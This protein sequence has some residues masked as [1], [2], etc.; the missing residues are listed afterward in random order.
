MQSRGAK[1]G[2]S[3]DTRPSYPSGRSKKASIPFSNN[4]FFDKLDQGIF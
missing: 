4:G 1:T 3:G 2:G